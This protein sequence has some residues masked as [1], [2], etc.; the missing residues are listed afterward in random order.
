M[1][2]NRW[3]AVIGVAIGAAAGAC[4]DAPGER[5]DARTESSI[6]ERA[7]APSAA[8]TVDTNIVFVDVR[9]DREYAA[10]HVEGAIHIPH[11]EMA[12]RY[13]EL[14]R[15]EDKQLVV[16][17][18]SGRRSGIA[19]RVLEDRGF[20]NVINGGGLGDLASQGVPTTA[21]CC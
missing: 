4:A 19:E 10:G 21:N 7:G 5:A 16:Y 20:D 14:E 18:R 1:K 6:A 12:E 3:M 8:A 2:L 9:T 17:C 13:Q 11:D 15:Y